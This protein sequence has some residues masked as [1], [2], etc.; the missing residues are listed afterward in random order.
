[1][2]VVTAD[3]IDSQNSV[4][5]V[6]SALSEVARLG[7]DD[8]ILP[9]D[10]TAGDEIQVATTRAATA[11]D[12]VLRLVAAETWSVGLGIGDVRTPLPDSTRAMGG[13]AFVAARAAV[14]SAK[15]RPNR[16]S[17]AVAESR[18]L[19]AATLEPIVDLLLALRQRRTPEGWELHELL[20]TGLTQAEAAKRLGITPQ[21]ASLRAIAAGL[22]LDR[23]AR[24]AIAALLSHAD[25]RIAA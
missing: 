4:D 16:F 19:P 18:I 25:E 8:L 23:E 20:E 6:E 11:L 17:V 3:Q 21:A 24:V 13:S 7:G 22:R 9:P 14:E 1:M 5:L 15:Q 2:F 12:L 10:R